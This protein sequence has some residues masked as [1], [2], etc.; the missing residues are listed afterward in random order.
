MY[1]SASVV[2]VS[3]WGAISSARPSPFFS[4][5]PCLTYPLGENPLEFLDKTYSTKTEGM[6]LLYGENCIILT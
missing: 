4:L 5:Q 3:T 2:A 1:L 6:E